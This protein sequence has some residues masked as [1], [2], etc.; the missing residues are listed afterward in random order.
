[1]QMVLIAVGTKQP[2]W[3]NEAYADY[4]D[5]MPPEYPLI[6]KEVKAEPRTLGKSVE[7][8]MAAEA[9]RIRA[10]MPAHARLV[11]LDE[12][13]SRLTSTALSE[14]LASWSEQ[15]DPVVIVIGGPDG[16]HESIKSAAKEKIRL[17]D[18]TLPHGMVR[19]L[20]AEQLYRAHSILK[21]HPYHRA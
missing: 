17:S 14:R 9:D 11:V 6:L 10:A 12:M 20:M 8:M 18:M 7:A 5:R 19:V 2:Q 13:G 16:L 1:M 21:G 3:V 15:S 4:A